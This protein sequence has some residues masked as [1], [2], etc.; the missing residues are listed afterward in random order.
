MI[1]RLFESVLYRDTLGAMAML[2]MM[3]VIMMITH[4]AAAAAWL[5]PLN[6]RASVET[7]PSS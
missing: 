4:A 1:A 5:N 7:C 2:V 6:I 3:N